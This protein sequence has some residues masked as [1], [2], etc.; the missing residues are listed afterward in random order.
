[1]WS[2]GN[3]AGGACAAVLAAG[4]AVTGGGPPAARADSRATPRGARLSPRGP[5]PVCALHRR[6]RYLLLLQSIPL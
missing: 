5:P 2:N 1:M 6:A 3:K 4:G